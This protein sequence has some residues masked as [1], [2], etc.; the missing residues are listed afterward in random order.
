MARDRYVVAISAGHRLAAQKRIGL[1]H[2][3][4]V[5][6]IL[7]VPE[8]GQIG[9]VDRA[10][11]QKGK[12]RIV[13]ARVRDFG[14]ALALASATDM[15]TTVPERIALRLQ[16][17]LGLALRNSPLTLPPIDI[18]WIWHQRRHRDP[19]LEWVRARAAEA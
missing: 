6:H 17:P 12:Q 15:L 9:I 4:S 2:F 13:G 18:H 8:E 7:T 3:L 19:L 1:Q 11:R 5:P 10:L 14:T 16:E